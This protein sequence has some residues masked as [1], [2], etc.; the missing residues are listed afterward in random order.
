MPQERRSKIDTAI[1]TVAACTAGGFVVGAG[2]DPVTALAVSVF[3]A[4]GLALASYI[5]KGG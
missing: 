2:H 4:G 3:L 5:A 1:I